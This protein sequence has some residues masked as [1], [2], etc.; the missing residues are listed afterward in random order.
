L[1]GFVGILNRDGAPVSEPLIR[2]LTR[3]LEFRGVDGTSLKVLGPVALGHA[4]LAAGPPELNPQQPLALDGLAWIVGDIRLDAREALEDKI[5]SGSISRRRASDAE[6]V[7][8]AW[9]RWGEECVHHIA[10]DFAF[11]I[12]DERLQTVF[13][14]RDHF[15]IRPFFYSLDDKCF[16]FGNTLDCVVEHPGVSVELDHRFLAQYLT[17]GYQF[18]PAITAYEHVR[19]LPQS[20]CITVSRGQAR[21]RR[22]WSPWLDPCRTGRKD[23]EIVDEFSSLLGQAVRDRVRGDRAAVF[24]SGGL[25]SSAVAAAAQG[26]LAGGG[27]GKELAGV[28][29]TYSRAFPDLEPSYAGKVAESLC[30]PLTILDEP[31]LEPFRDIRAGFR[32]QPEPFGDFYRATSI[33][34]CRVA[35]AAA[36]EVLTGQ[37]GDELLAKEYLIN[38]LHRT[39]L[40]AILWGGW[41]TLKGARYRP[42]IGLRAFLHRSHSAHLIFR[43][44]PVPDWLSPELVALAPTGHVVSRDLPGFDQPDQWHPRRESLFYLFKINLA[45]VLESYDPG[46]TGV[47]A[48]VRF[49]YLDL[50]L[51][52]FAL[53]LPPYPWCNQKYVLRA[54]LS[55]VVDDAIVTRVKT[56]LAGDP[57]R[58][59]FRVA[60][61]SFESTTNWAHPI[62]AKFIRIDAWREA[63]ES[64]AD[65]HQLMMPVGLAHWLE[66]RGRS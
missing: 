53:S 8:H 3:R 50:R 62:L 51:V 43:S 28:C 20:Q 5:G 18:D 16:V 36:V 38:S 60:R 17:N 46:D 48:T 29:A 45:P 19:R 66:R 23:G 9:R 47:P 27:P 57:L 58:S 1:S 31:S 35:R 21:R 2:E 49:P 40:A 7:L 30:I 42:P 44:R 6:L 10:G 37:V 64:G 26:R 24:L 55:G 33:D 14:A 25:D 15:G 41:R 63:W 13:C 32:P 22:Y 54:A 4:L 61:P 12:W 56:P 11:A 65:P 59:Y 39:P 52:R 34:S